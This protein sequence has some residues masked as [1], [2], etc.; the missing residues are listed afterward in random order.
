VEEVEEFPKL[1]KFPL[2]QNLKKPPPQNHEVEEV[3]EAEVDASLK[4]KKSPQVQ[5]QKISL[6]VAVDEEDVE[7]VEDVVEEDVWLC[8]MTLMMIPVNRNRGTFQVVILMMIQMICI[9][10]K[11][12]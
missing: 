10:I 3:A 7:D 8:L 11:Y 12:I 2:I 1:K 6:G 5:I 9:W 4:Q